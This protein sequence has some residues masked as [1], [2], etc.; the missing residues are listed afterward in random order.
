MN[1]TRVRRLLFLLA[2]FSLLGCST[3]EQQV[4]VAQ[5]LTPEHFKR[6]ATVEDDDRR[7]TATITTQSGF[8]PKSGLLRFVYD[9]NYMRAVIDKKTG[10][11]TYQLY[12]SIF[13][14]ASDWRFYRKAN[15]ETP[16]GLE[17]VDAKFLKPPLATHFDCPDHTS[18]VCT[19][20]EHVGFT[21]DRERLESIAKL[22]EPG[23]RVEWRFTFVPKDGDEF[24]DTLLVAEVVGFLQAVD[25]YK[26]TLGS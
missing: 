23:K 11:V 14:Q 4:Q 26:K 1:S 8:R 13:Y 9:D 5:T 17:S 6:T 7:P 3:T 10:N 18:S 19:Y 12:Q 21:I 20:N 2:L 16:N 24:N 22:Y 25:S 15:Y